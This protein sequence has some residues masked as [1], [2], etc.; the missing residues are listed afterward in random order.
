MISTIVFPGQPVPDSRQQPPEREPEER[1]PP[2]VAVALG[3]VQMANDHMG[4]RC[5]I[6]HRPF[7]GET[8]EVVNVDLHPKQEAAFDRACNL[9]G[10]YFD[11]EIERMERERLLEAADFRELVYEAGVKLGLENEIQQEQLDSHAE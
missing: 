7:E 5:F 11:A 6:R 8:H 3:F 4:P 2:A 1:V 9:I 10:T